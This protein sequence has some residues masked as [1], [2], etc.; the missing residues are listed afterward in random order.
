MNILNFHFDEKQDCLDLPFKHLAVEAQMKLLLL[1]SDT[2]H[3]SG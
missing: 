1:L 3:D 2:A